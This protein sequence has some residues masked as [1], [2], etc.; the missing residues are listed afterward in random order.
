MLKNPL[1]VGVRQLPP[2]VHDKYVEHA[3]LD[4]GNNTGNMVF[5]EAL[6]RALGGAR[7]G[8]F[9]FAPEE[10]E[11][12][13]SI[14]IAAANWIN[15]YD[16]FG[17]L[18]AH[19]E[20]VDLPVFLVGVGAQ[21][22]TSMEYPEVQPGT[23]RLLQLVADRSVSIAARGTFSCEVMEHYG[24]KSAIP[25]GCP[26]LTLVGREGPRIRPVEELS[27]ET[28]AMHAT[29]HLFSS[30][31]DLQTYLYRQAYANGADLIL[32]SELADMYFALGR[33]NN[34]EIIARAL[35]TLEKVYGEPN[36]DAITQY[37]TAHAKVFMNFTSWIEYM[38]TKSFCFGSRIHGT[39]ASIAAGTSATLIAHDS[40][41]LEMARSMNIPY[42]P[43][44]DVSI[45]KPLRLE[46]FYVPDQFERL[47]AGYAEYF[48]RFMG[49]FAQNG[50]PIAN[51]YQI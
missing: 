37:L 38:R 46:D 27:F 8:S 4:L 29:R 13:D 32:Q 28:S 10:L 24:I 12:R 19:L 40:R 35:P 31:D 39:V 2:G 49:Y 5:T 50:L 20:R 17:W 44:S 47:R 23:L 42:I 14:V 22:S 30:T 6:L 11:G 45:D 43:A 9:S 1:V 36:T 34:P 18:A 7:W 48:A 16:D 51:D 33:R 3:L 15:S 25:T 41:T 21:A 26:S